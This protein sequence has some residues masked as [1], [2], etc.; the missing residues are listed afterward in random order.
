MYYIC[1]T[2]LSGLEGR[3]AELPE[4]WQ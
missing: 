4:I 2:T 1:T 3:A